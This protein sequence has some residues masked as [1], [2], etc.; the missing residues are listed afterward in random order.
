MKESFKNLFEDA[1]KK[2]EET[3]DSA[4][5]DL[6]EALGDVFE[7]ASR[8]LEEIKVSLSDAA[9]KLK[10]EPEVGEDGTE[11]EKSDAY[12]FDKLKTDLEEVAKEFEETVKEELGHISEKLNELKDKSRKYKKGQPGSDD[13]NKAPQPDPDEFVD[14]NP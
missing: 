9:E 8:L 6:K 2:V 1:K 11:K 13:P 14:P 3:I 4:P 7:N 12:S 5:H 10:K